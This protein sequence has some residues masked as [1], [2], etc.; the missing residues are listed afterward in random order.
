MA[1]RTEGDACI[2]LAIRGTQYMRHLRGRERKRCLKRNFSLPCLRIC[3]LFLP[4]RAAEAA[5]GVPNKGA[6]YGMLCPAPSRV[7]FTHKTI[8]ILGF[9]FWAPAPQPG[10]DVVVPGPATLFYPPTLPAPG[11]LVKGVR[12]SSWEARLFGAD[13]NLMAQWHLA[14]CRLTLPFM[15]PPTCHL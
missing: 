11:A 15:L 2:L 1:V 4:P 10:P 5:G 3:L 6:S 8:S 7:A 13:L 9:S 12:A 14:P